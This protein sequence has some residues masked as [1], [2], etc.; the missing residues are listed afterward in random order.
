MAFWKRERK[1]VKR[2]STAGWETRFPKNKLH[3]TLPELGQNG[4]DS[5]RYGR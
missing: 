2:K 1:K 4:H 5:P 3:R